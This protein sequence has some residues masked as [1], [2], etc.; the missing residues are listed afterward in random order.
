MFNL[1]CPLVILSIKLVEI[2]LRFFTI[3]S[4]TKVFLPI[5]KILLKGS[6][7]VEFGSMK[8]FSTKNETLFNMQAQGFLLKQCYKTYKLRIERNTV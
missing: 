4:D 6:K 1:K 2:R 8:H 3:E 7:V 5:T